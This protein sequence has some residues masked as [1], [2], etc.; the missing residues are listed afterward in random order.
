MGLC[1]NIPLIPA[2]LQSQKNTVFSSDWPWSWARGDWHA[3]KLRLVCTVLY[4]EVPVDNFH[5]QKIPV[6][7]FFCVPQL[8]I[9]D[10]PF[11]VRFLRMWP[12]LFVCLFFIEPLRLS[13]SVFVDVACWVFF[14]PAFTRLG[15][16]RQDL[17]VLSM[18]CMCSQTRPRFILS[19]ESFGGMDPEPMLTPREKSL[20]RKNSPQRRIEPTTLCQAGQ[21]A[22]HTTN[23]TIPTPSSVMTLKKIATEIFNTLPCGQRARKNRSSPS[24]IV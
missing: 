8:N 21:R 24:E 17:W 3:E 16:E 5:W 22:Q 4:C 12:V 15:H 10:S 20:Y 9:W 18:E 19:S 23:W 11:L 13:H 1:I 2:N 14:L 6:L 7:P